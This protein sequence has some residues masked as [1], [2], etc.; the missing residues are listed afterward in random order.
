MGCPALV[1]TFI[2]QTP[3]HKTQGTQN[4][5]QKDCKNL[6]PRTPAFRKG[7]VGRTEKLHP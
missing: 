4:T 1:D 5:G 6:R 2:L 7:F 3:K